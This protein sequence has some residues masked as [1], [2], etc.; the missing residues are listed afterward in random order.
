[1]QWLQP[2]DLP[3]ALQRGEVGVDLEMAVGEE[4]Q[5]PKGMTGTVSF[6][7]FL[8]TLKTNVGTSMESQI[9]PSS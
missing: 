7:M 2:L 9:G 6:A 1:M 3:Q 8:A 5:L 4:G